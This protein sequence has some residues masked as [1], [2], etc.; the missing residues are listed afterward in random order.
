MVLTVSDPATAI[1]NMWFFIYKTWAF[2]EN[3]PI[4]KN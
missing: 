2:L 3:G 4:C 1:H